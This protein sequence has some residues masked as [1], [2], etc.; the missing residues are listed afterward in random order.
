MCPFNLDMIGFK[1]MYFK[2]S[3]HQNILL[4]DHNQ[5]TDALETEQTFL[6]KWNFLKNQLT[7][8]KQNRSP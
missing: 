5:L 7:Q 3:K 6:C 8:S 2:F 1:F 4:K